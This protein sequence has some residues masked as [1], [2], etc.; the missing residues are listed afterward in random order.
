MV[1]SWRSLLEVETFRSELT[2]MDTWETSVFGRSV[3]SRGIHNLLVCSRSREER[4]LV[5]LSF[6]VI[7]PKGE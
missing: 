5:R 2:V 4:P 7:Y 6:H 3:L 1:D